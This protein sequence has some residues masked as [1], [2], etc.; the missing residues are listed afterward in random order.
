MTRPHRIGLPPGWTPPPPP[1]ARPF[2]A[3]LPAMAAAAW[4]TAQAALDRA[5]RSR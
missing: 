2:Y 3:L 5:R 1:P 4:R